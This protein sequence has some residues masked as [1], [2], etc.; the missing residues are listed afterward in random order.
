MPSNNGVFEQ[1]FQFT[2][3][4]EGGYVK[5]ATDPGGETKYG[6]SKRA[7]PDLDIKNLSLEQARSLYRE[8]YWDK[9]FCSDKEPPVAAALF[10]TAVNVGVVRA[11]TWLNQV[12]EDDVA[13]LNKRKDYY[14]KLI[15]EHPKLGKYK[16]GWI[17][18]VLD[19]RKLC[20][21]LRQEVQAG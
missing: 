7:F 13:L 12:E 1:C 20:D 10:D 16:N 2:I 5:D 8:S 19:L 18:R 11:L 4:W 9:C 17:N 14:L 15:E 21:I 3:K 6:I